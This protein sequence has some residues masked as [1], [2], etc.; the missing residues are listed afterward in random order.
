MADSPFEITTS[1]KPKKSSMKGI[2]I[3]LVVVLFLA[4]GVFVG[5]L[6]VRQQQDIREK[7]DQ[8]QCPAAQAC[9]HPDQPELLSD[10]SEGGVDPNDSLCNARGRVG[11]CG[12][13]SY[14]CPG[15]NQ[16]WTRNMAACPSSTASPTAT[17][18][19]TATATATSTSTATATATGT[20]K[21]TA[22]PTASPTK[23]S[24]A[25]AT[26]T[27][28]KQPIPET[29]TGWATYASA[30]LGVLVIIGALLLAL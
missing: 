25:K 9:P 4:L 6:L 26:T 15:P 18:T 2:I 3:S 5:V 23:S 12:G 14:C 30:G 1:G 7:A 27:P 11:T 19:G 17:A 13:A 10:C 21:G 22:S 29:G 16:A 28:T 24:T 8:A 20:A